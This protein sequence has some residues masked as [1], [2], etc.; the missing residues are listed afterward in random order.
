MSRVHWQPADHGL[1]SVTEV[2]IS[3]LSISIVELYKLKLKRDTR[4]RHQIVGSLF[5]CSSVLTPWHNDKRCVYPCISADLDILYGDRHVE[6]LCYNET[7]K[8][9]FTYDV[10]VN[11]G[12]IASVV[13][14]Y[15]KLV[16]GRVCTNSITAYQLWTCRTVCCRHVLTTVDI[17]L[18]A[19][20]KRYSYSRHLIGFSNCHGIVYAFKYFYMSYRY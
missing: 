4:E 20:Y 13:V 16:L 19:I 9:K 15:G 11:V 12:R 2:G 5:I 14:A 7:Q 17:L 10:D 6:L 8:C 1:I 3:L 18:R